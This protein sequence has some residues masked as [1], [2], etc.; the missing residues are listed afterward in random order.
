[1]YAGLNAD[2]YTYNLTSQAVNAQGYTEANVNTRFQA[3]FIP[4][5]QFLGFYAN[6]LEV[7]PGE[8]TAVFNGRMHTNGDLYLSEEHCPPGAEFLGQ[9]TIVGSGISGTVPLTRGRKFN[10]GNRGEV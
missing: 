3:R 7:A 10:T 6:D 1:P 9:L 4:V 2:I 8:T 5:F